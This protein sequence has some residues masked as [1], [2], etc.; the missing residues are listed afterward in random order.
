[1]AEGKLSSWWRWAGREYLQPFGEAFL[2][3]MVIRTFVVQAFSIP[4]GSMEPT[5]HGQE[6]GGDRI[7]VNKLIY[8]IRL[9]FTDK[10]LFSFRAPRPGDIVVFKTVGIKGTGG[11]P[12]EEE[13][14]DYVKRV[15]AVGGQSVLIRDGILH[16]DGQPTDYHRFTYDHYYYCSKDRPG[17]FM[18]YAGG[19]EIVV[20]PGHLFCL[21]DNSGSSLDSR[22]W[23]FVP[24]E[25]VLGR[26]VLCWWPPKRIGRLQ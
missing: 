3:A 14:N 21:G 24:E 22:Y 15:A 9:P 8:G 1:M 25:N 6:P 4:T 26:A 12:D 13:K 16:L 7:F 18:R 23:G 11:T 20:P 2:L 19:E 17:C 5:I 10:R